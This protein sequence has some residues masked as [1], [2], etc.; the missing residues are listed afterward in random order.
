[1]II[2]ALRKL[3]HALPFRP[4]VIRMASGEKYVVPHPD[5]ISVSPLGSQIIVYDEAD[6]LHMLS[7]LLMEAATPLQGRERQRSKRRAA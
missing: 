5:F 4:Y 2:D 1:M 6:R 7:P 3:N